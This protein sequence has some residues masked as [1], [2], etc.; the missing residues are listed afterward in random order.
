MQPLPFGTWPSPIAAAD[1]ARSSVTITYVRALNGAPYWLESRPNEQGRYVIVTPAA[2]GG[3]TELTP[4]G[5][6]ARTRVHEY[7]GVPYTLQRGAVYFSN[8]VDQRLY[9]QR[10]GAEPADLFCADG[11]PA[12]LG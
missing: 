10:A 6:N 4:P 7:G 2:D 1:L 8:F 11:W 3:F 5:F 9:A 12:E